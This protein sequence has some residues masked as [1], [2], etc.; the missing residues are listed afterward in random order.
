[1]RKLKMP[2]ILS[3]IVIVCVA[4]FIIKDPSYATGEQIADYLRQDTAKEQEAITFSD[5][6]KGFADELWM[7]SSFI[8][9]NGFVAKTLGMKGLYSSMGMYVTDDNY[10]V[11]AY[12]ETSTD[13]EIEQ[14]TKLKSFLDKQGINLLYVNQPTKYTDD[15]FFSE[16][17]GKETY[18]NRNTDVF[19]QRLKEAGI[20]AIDLRE[21]IQEDGM[22][23]R[24]M[25]YRTDHHWTT[26]SALWACGKIA[27]G[28]NTYCGYS[29]DTTLYDEENYEFIEYPNS[30]LGEQGR[31]MAQTYVGLDD[32]TEIKPRFETSYVFRS[33]TGKT[34]GTFDNFIREDMYDLEADV[35]DATSWHYSY[36]QRNCDNNNVEQGK[37]LLLGDSYGQYTEPFLSLAVHSIDS[38][39]LRSQD[40]DFDLQKYI[41]D[42][43]YDTVIICY[44]QFMIGAHDN[45]SS[46][47][48]KMFS[49]IT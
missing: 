25:F 15:S 37:V 1:M 20:S 17:F 35:Y 19:M 21:C 30:W 45:L 18:S 6:E 34:N 44:A 31:K 38:L 12:N 47:N 7:R 28:L 41:L 39:I 42:N 8:D 11:S 26:R 29:I 27:K 40:D 3:V 43:Q 2:K 16:E 22:N 23:V 48:Y 10:I 4:F 32:F 49:F 24:D 33:S 13:Y 14:I 9:L 46:A 36:V 5:I